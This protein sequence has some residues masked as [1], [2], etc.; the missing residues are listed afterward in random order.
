MLIYAICGSGPFR[1]DSHITNK[2]KSPCQLLMK[3][4][5]EKLT[6]NRDFQQGSDR[7][8]NLTRIIT[9]PRSGFNQHLT[10]VTEKLLQSEWLSTTLVDSVSLPPPIPLMEA[11]CSSGQ[12]AATAQSMMNND[13]QALGVDMQEITRI[14]ANTM[15]PRESTCPC[16]YD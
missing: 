2:A 6:K 10:S 1:D 8:A 13:Q 7:W 3:Q 16:G 15:T 9:Q 5:R 4:T 12:A 14:V 11:Q